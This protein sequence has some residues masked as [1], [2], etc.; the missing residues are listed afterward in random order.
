MATRLRPSR[1]IILGLAAFATLPWALSA[2]CVQY[3]PVVTRPATLGEELMSIDSARKSGLLTDEEYAA[4][5]AQTI[6]EW[7]KIGDTPVD[8]VQVGEP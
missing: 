6:A 8:A 5:R 7:K 3:Q 4:R 2:A 1:P